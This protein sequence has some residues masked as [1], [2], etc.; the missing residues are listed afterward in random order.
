M[1][2]SAVEIDINSKF[3]PELRFERFFVCSTDPGPRQICATKTTKCLQILN[4]LYFQFE[5]ERVA[6]RDQIT[7][8]KQTTLTGVPLTEKKL[9]LFVYS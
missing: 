8:V 6:G 2:L 7:V 1:N 4:A 9:T 3:H 5:S